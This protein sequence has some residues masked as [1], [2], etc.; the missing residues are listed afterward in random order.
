ME[1]L[2]SHG[3]KMELTPSSQPLVEEQLISYNKSSEN[4]DFYIPLNPIIPDD[5]ETF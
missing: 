4:A 3:G 1:V 5:Y 2:N